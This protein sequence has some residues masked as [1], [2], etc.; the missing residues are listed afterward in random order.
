M[1]FMKLL[2]DLLFSHFATGKS[3]PVFAFYSTMVKHLWYRT[4]N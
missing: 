4:K 1:E 3:L 2:I